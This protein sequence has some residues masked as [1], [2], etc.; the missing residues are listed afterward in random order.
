VTASVAS[1][2]SQAQKNGTEVPVALTGAL[3]LAALRLSEKK[4][5]ALRP[6][7]LLVDDDGALELLTGEP[8][9]GDEYAA[10]ELRNG[11]VLP[12]DPRVLVYAAGAL[13][14]ELVTLKPPPAGPGRAEGLAGPLAPVIR[15]AM[16]ERQQRYKSL[17]DM[18][19]AIERIQGRPSREDE[20][21]IL[22]AVA[23]STPLPPQQKL[24]KLE[25]GR[26]VASDDAPP[27]SSPGSA[28]PQPIFTQ[29]WD[30][31]EPQAQPPPA[32]A[33]VPQS[34]PEA[35]V[36]S[37]S[38]REELE[39]ERRA[40]RE[41]KAAIEARSQD[42]A[43]LG[44]RLS[45]LEEQVRSSL[46]PPL[47]PAASLAREVK[48]LLEERRF[49]E[50][51]RAL[52][53]PRVQNDAV[54]QFALGETLSSMPDPDGARFSRAEAAFRRAAHLDATWA[55]PRA[56]LGALL[57]RKGRHAEAREQLY[58]ALKI[59]A[60]CPEALAVL[61]WRR[62]RAP[63][64]AVSAAVSALAAAAV[65]LAFRPSRS[66]APV[67]K[68][69]PVTERAPVA[70]ASVAPVPQLPPLPLPPV[71]P[72]PAAPAAPVAGVPAPAL[73]PRADPAPPPAPRRQTRLADRE[74]DA[75][76]RDPPPPRPEPRK[77]KVV[78]AGSGDR[79][80]AEAEA[81]RGDRALRAFDTKTAEAAFNAALK[82]D[83]SF[84]SAHRG[85]GMVYV[86][87][88]KNAEAKAAYSRYLQLAP[89]APD[90]EQIARLLA[91]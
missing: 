25:L 76:P 53:N 6:Y 78:A 65:V 36:G 45:L 91:R 47:V 73:S 46:P 63:A 64:F 34:G 27:G 54:L 62:P 1:F 4:M 22:A 52:L 72:P 71:T 24:A 51:E 48:Q 85:M 13:G 56:R 3:L 89:D 82:L 39:A 49:S 42:L 66:V 30:P 61:S 32:A 44:T 57:W 23:A 68:G 19:R 26:A 2:L 31:L 74:P 17:G 50:A 33:P 83:P 29:V 87:L 16:S 70:A 59:D 43:Q 60:A 80:A 10:P 86:L 28:E 20:R 35:N 77:K 84:P 40:R 5:Q 12:E 67:T 75:E 58:A 81:A 9:T 14:Y 79:A 41:L 37:D 69:D 88:G 21:L 90:R 18:A 15:K 55:Q 8:P 38:L 7:Q 11:A